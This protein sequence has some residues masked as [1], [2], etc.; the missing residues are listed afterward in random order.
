MPRKK[1]ETHRDIVKKFHNC[2][3]KSLNLSCEYIHSPLV[4]IQEIM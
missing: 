2:D 3:E 4:H 1:Q